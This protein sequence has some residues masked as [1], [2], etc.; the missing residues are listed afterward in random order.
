MFI[1]PNQRSLFV[2]FKKQKIK[3]KY[4]VCL[5][6]W[7]NLVLIAILFLLLHLFFLNWNRKVKVIQKKIQMNASNTNLIWE[8][9]RRRRKYIS[10]FHLQIS[11][12]IKNILRNYTICLREFNWFY[13]LWFRS[14]AFMIKKSSLRLKNQQSALQI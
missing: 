9:R 13:L 11:F 8:R 3:L 14:F 2:W 4:T 1:Y 6:I 10:C 7:I 5:S 12:S